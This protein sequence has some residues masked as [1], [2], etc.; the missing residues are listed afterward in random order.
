MT[1]SCNDDT[2]A[3]TLCVWASTSIDGSEKEDKAAAAAGNVNDSPA[4]GRGCDDGQFRLVE[5]ISFGSG[6]ALAVALATLPGTSNT[7]VLA[8]G[9]DD[10]AVRLYVAERIGD[11]F[12]LA[13]ALRGHDDWVSD[14]Q[15]LFAMSNNV[16]RY[17]C[18]TF[19]VFE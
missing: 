5:T 17:N 2:F 10:C 9:G 16:G 14:A 11:P 15:P 13:V 7:P 19:D 1:R 4:G 18:G 6:F 3:G 8:V 12:Q